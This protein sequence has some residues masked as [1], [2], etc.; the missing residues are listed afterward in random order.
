ML[1]ARIA[2]FKALEFLIVTL[3]A[4][5]CQRYKTGRD[6][7]RQDHIGTTFFVSGALEW[8]RPLSTALER[9]AWD[10]RHNSRK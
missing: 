1:T 2:S 3:Q 4:M 6:L 5:L 7:V 9:N 10:M 8:V